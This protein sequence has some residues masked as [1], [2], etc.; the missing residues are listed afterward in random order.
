LAGITGD[1]TLPEQRLG[2]LDPSP[3]TCKECLDLLDV[4]AGL[5]LANMP[6][7]QGA[8]GFAR[9]IA[10]CDACR[11]EYESLVHVL[12]TAPGLTLSHISSLRAK[13]PAFADAI[14]RITPATSWQVPAHV[15]AARWFGQAGLA[16][17][18]SIASPTAMPAPYPLL[19]DAAQTAWGLA[20]IEV[21]AQREPSSSDHIELNVQVA[22]DQ[23]VRESIRVTLHW[24]DQTCT[25]ILDQQGRAKFSGI[26]LDLLFDSD[27][28]QAK[29]ALDMSLEPAS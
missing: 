4:A 16:Q 24:A 26:A 28:H 15:L 13:L 10:S 18:R 29:S 1:T 23:P 14:A 11:Q 19:V 8:P 25:S 22:F 3:L 2:L 6:L 20:G 17:A 7:E 12:R 5:T 21:T 27:T 9:H